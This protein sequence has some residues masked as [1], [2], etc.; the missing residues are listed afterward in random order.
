MDQRV[1]TEWCEFCERP[2]SANGSDFSSIFMSL[3][4]GPLSEGDKE[5]LSKIFSYLPHSA[6]TLHTLL[7][8]GT[9]QEGVTGDKILTLAAAD[10]VDKISI[11]DEPE[12]LALLALG[13]TKVV[14]DECEFRQI[15][16]SSMNLRLVDSLM[17]YYWRI[18]SSSDEKTLAMCNAFYGIA[19][20]LPLQVALAADL[21]SADVQFQNY[22][23]L[24][25]RGSDIAL[26]TSGAVLFFYCS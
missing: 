1:L 11:V 15:C 9:A 23:E 5:D 7:R 26:D 12:V 6:H 22:I 10:L 19:N 17:D 8:I 3:F 16:G 18:T 24:Y 21:L 20:S 4:T 13:V 25:L 2:E 14:T